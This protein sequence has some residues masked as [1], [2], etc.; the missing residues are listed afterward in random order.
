MDELAAS[1]TQYMDEEVAKEDVKVLDPNATEEG[2]SPSREVLV[3]VAEANTPLGQLVR[4][5]APEVDQ[6]TVTAQLTDLP[7]S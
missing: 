3:E 1:V 2:T 5:P 6:P 7:S 4:P